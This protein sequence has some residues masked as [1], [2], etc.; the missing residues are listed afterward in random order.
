[1]DRNLFIQS[2]ATVRVL[3][4]RLLDKA[5]F[6]R[7]IEAKD[8]QEALRILQDSWYQPFVAKLGRPE[9]Y[10]K[11]LTEA[12]DAFYAEA[13]TLSPDGKIIS[14]PELQFIYHNLKVLVKEYV[15]KKPLNELFVSV[16]D[17]DI[18]KLRSGVEEGKASYE[19]EYWYR[20]VK[21][22]IDLFEETKD[23]QVIDIYFDNKYF[24]ELAKLAD[25][26]GAPMIVEYVEDLIDFT[27]IKTLLRCSNQKRDWEFVKKVIIHGGNIDMVKL[28]RYFQEKMSSES[29]IFRPYR[30]YFAVKNG[31]EAYESTGTLS[32]FDKLMDNYFIGKLKDAK[33]I[34]YGPEVIFAYEMAK[35][36]EIKNLRIVLMSKLAGLSPDVIRERMRESYV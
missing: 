17:L 10:E 19:V 16:G 7:L 6:D 11:A 9:D 5:F 3:E 34:N 8:L 24:E 35:G 13:S 1:M 30:I 36:F 21:E 26:I 28:E 14:V 22:C 29:L 23:P 20:Q 25:E 18:P 4:K 32:V 33:M 12:Q 31:L 2:G 27:N 15:L